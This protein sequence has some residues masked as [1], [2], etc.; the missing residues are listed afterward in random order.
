MMRHIRFQSKKVKKGKKGTVLFLLSGLFV[1][2]PCHN[3]E[4]AFFYI[5]TAGSWHKKSPIL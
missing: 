4:D 1:I 5:D 2:P 3:M